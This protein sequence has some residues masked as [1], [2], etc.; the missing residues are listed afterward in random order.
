MGSQEKAAVRRVKGADH[1]AGL[2]R[3]KKFDDCRYFVSFGGATDRDR[4][5]KSILLLLREPAP[6][7]GS[8]GP[9]NID[10]IETDVMLDQ[11]KTRATHKMIERGFRDIVG[12]S[13]LEN[14]RSVTRGAHYHSPFAS[15]GDHLARDS[16]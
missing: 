12:E 2:V 6:L 11:D 13:V 10:G 16:L 8:A 14:H 4:P 9:P 5:R 3:K 15:G 7:A 1:I